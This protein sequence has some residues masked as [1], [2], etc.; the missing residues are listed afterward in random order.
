MLEGTHHSQGQGGDS[1][2]S[3]T[4]LPSAAV[5]CSAAQR[6]AAGLGVQEHVPGNC[7]SSQHLPAGPSCHPWLGHLERAVC[8]PNKLP[9][10]APTW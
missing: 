6:S 7:T 4:Q 8:T 9:P 2:L 1:S 3:A 5:A 10:P